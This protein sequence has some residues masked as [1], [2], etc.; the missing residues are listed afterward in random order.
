MHNT[1]MKISQ[2]EG[3]Y[4]TNLF[5][6]CVWRQ[7][8]FF[9]SPSNDGSRALAAIFILCLLHYI[10]R[11]VFNT[12]LANPTYLTLPWYSNLCGNSYR[13]GSNIISGEMCH[14]HSLLT[15]IFCFPS[16]NM[17]HQPILQLFSNDNYSSLA[18]YTY[19]RNSWSLMLPNTR[20][21]SCQNDAKSQLCYVYI[22]LYWR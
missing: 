11:S 6:R 21:T 12:S 1:M 4:T 7:F 2:T 9:L 8:L 14:C 5:V 20:F 22:N 17:T 15:Y 19:W 10:L 13:K 16:E 18:N 3:L